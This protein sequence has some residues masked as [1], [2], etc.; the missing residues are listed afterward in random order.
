MIFSKMRKKSIILIAQ[1]SPSIH[2]QAIMAAHLAHLMQNWKD[3]DIHLINASYT[4][5]RSCLGK[6][7]VR[8]VI[9]WISY[10]VITLKLCITQPVDT[11]V[12]THSFFPGPFLKDSAFLWLA[13]IMKKKMIVWVHMD[14]NRF[15][16]SS[17]SSLLSSYA[18]LVLRFPQQWIACA[19]SLID[20]WPIYFDRR[21]VSAICNGIDDPEPSSQNRSGELLRVVYISSMTQEKGWQ[22][23]LVAAQEICSEHE[24]ITF[25]FY[26]GAGANESTDRLR[27]VFASSSHPLR[28]RWNGELWGDEKTRV[29][30]QAHLFCLPSWTEAF[31]LAV[32]DAMACALPVVAT[33]VGG[34][35]DAIIEGEN[36]WLCLPRES[37]SLLAALRN[38]L[39]NREK[40]AMIGERNRQRFLDEFSSSAFDKKWHALL[41]NDEC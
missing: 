22:E 3:A 18:K 20:Q 4:N 39:S 9:L 24:H 7:S 23:L 40:F 29:L 1:T 2:G 36:G 41:S 8:K 26:G 14:P 38:A 33:R 37:S 16:W 11:I 34:I 25:D 27:E 32:I 21:K 35:P 13:R 10:L 31:P 6:F 17:S 5:D 30:T 12:M 15:P 28:I 19:P